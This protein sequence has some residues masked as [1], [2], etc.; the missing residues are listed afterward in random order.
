M[1]KLKQIIGIDYNTIITELGDHSVPKNWEQYIIKKGK[2]ETPGPPIIWGEP[3]SPEEVEPGYGYVSDDTAEEETFY[4]H[5]DHLGS[6]SYITDQDGNITQYTAYLPYGELLI[7]EH[8]SSE[9]L[10]YKFNGKELDDETGLYYYGARY[11]QPVASVWYGVD[12]LFERSVSE[13]SYVFCKGNPIRFVD[14]DGR[15][16]WPWERA[17]LIEYRGNG[18]FGLRMENFSRS[19]RSN[20]RI[21]NENPK[22]WRPGEIGINTELGRVSINK[23]AHENYT[24]GR[25]PPGIDPKDGFVHV[26]RPIA[27][28]T[29]QGDKRFHK[30]DPMPVRGSARMVGA[31]AL[32]DITIM[33]LDTYMTYASFWDSE[34]LQ[35]QRGALVDAVKAVDVHADIIPSKYQE[36][37]DRLGA[38][39]NYVFQGENSTKDQNVTKIGQQIL[40][41]VGRYDNET[42]KYKPF[43]EK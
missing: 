23:Y 25:K 33:A 26:K 5:S 40:K 11:L 42:K 4:Y 21:A 34:A 8:S 17:S 41:K 36:S 18:V 7:D 31:I 13:G 14:P 24:I 10:P 32:L 12:P 43:I 27:Q 16:S 2:G 19:T 22:N 38:I 6:T 3:Q 9:D 30:F 35:K 28:S 1:T 39:V 20:F 29:G 37:N 15:W